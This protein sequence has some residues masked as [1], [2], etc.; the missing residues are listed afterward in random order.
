MSNKDCCQ[1]PV[2]NVHTPE[3][4]LL[5]MPTVTTVTISEDELSQAVAT[6]VNIKVLSAVVAVGADPDHVV[7][8]RLTPA[9]AT[10][11]VLRVVG[12]P[13]TSGATH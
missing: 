6:Y 4:P 13:F 7:T 5:S 9:N 2:G 3:C 12:L 1:T 11:H 8:I 10:E